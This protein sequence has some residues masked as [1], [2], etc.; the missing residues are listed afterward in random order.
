MSGIVEA[1]LAKCSTDAER[2][3]MLREAL[4]REKLEHYETMKR[5]VAI[6]DGQ[7]KR[8]AKARKLIRRFEERSGLLEP[9]ILGAYRA[10]DW[11]Q[12]R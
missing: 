3:T 9:S 6:A 4:E 5:W 2:V 12:R 11:R 10:L 8:I 1:L 7:A